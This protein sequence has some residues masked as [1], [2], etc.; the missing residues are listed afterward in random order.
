MVEVYAIHLLPDE[1]FLQV[2]WQLLSYMPAPAQERFSRFSRGA[3]V[4]RSLLGE[5]LA[6][7]LLT[8]RLKI[9]CNEIVFAVGANGKPA[10]PKGGNLHFNISHSG[11]WAVCA[12]ANVPVGVDVERLRKVNPGLAE[13]FFSPDEVATLK[14]LPPEMQTTKFIQLWTLKESFLKAIGRGL[15]RTLNSFSVRQQG[16]MYSITGD[17]SAGEYH[18]KLFDLA[19]DYMLAV[20][21]PSAD[22]RESVEIITVDQMLA[23]FAPST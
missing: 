13:R 15:T 22:F 23:A 19:L 11:Q 14:A 20:C 4:Q 18:L 5:M 6:R 10:F 7:Y 8:D 3:D 16:G 9:N 1:E 21:A 2:S 17:D 12:L